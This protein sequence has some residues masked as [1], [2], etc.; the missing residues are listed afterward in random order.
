MK[1][2]ASWVDNLK[3]ISTLAIITLHVAADGV[4]SQFKPGSDN[5]AWWV[6]N[7][8]DSLCRFGTPVFVMITGSLLLKQSIGGRDFLKRRLNRILLPFAFWF[9]IYLIF[10]FA[11]K[12]RDEGVTGQMETFFPWFFQQLL[13]GPEVHL[14][15]VYMIIGVYLFIP[16]IKPWAQTSSNAGLLYFIVIWLVTLIINQQQY[17]V[18]NTPFELKY[19]SGYIGYVV[20]GYYISERMVIT[21]AM[22]TWAI[23]LFFIGFIITLFGTY[24]ITDANGK[25]SEIF[26]SRLSVNVL[27]MAISVFAFFKGLP[28]RN[29]SNTFSVIRSTVSR[30]GFGIYLNHI[31]ILIIL[32]YFNVNYRL[33]NPWFSIPMT[34]VICLSISC[35]IIYTLNKL[36]YGKNVS[37]ST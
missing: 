35:L 33:F 28:E 20:L 12:I 11:L 23:F 2:T 29:V 4:I 14:W 6:A 13:Q 31:I 34:V 25:F 17:I 16:I 3:L 24:V 19:F 9:I 32:S 36:P 8:Y 30:Y 18:W 5:A 7:F 37:G 22:R 15:Y 10:H 26:Y 21:K 27:L 1:P